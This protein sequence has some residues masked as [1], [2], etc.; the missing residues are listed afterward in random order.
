MGTQ[1]HI[2]QLGTAP[3]FSAHV[4]C[5]Q[6]VAHLDNCS[7]LAFLHDTAVVN[8]IHYNICM[9]AFVQ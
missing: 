3:H 6:T 7:A 9:Q 5:G 1:L 2:P 8:N 4:C